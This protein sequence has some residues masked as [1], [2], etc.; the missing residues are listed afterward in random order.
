MPESILE[1]S[2]SSVFAAELARLNAAISRINEQIADLKQSYLADFL[3]YQD[4]VEA[5]VMKA[6]AQV[7]VEGLIGNVHL[8]PNGDVFYTIKKP[9][10]AGTISSNSRI[11]ASRVP[12]AKVRRIS[13]CSVVPK[14]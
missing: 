11:L 6:G 8:Q 2:K 14:S 1:K 4:P 7:Y 9:N 3:A 12:A 13:A 5:T 10:S